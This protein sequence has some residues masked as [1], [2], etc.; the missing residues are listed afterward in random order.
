MNEE[1]LL[2][3]FESFGGQQK[4]GVDFKTWVSKI[5]D[6]EDYKKGMFENFGGQETLKA[7]YEDWNQK[8]FGL[9]KK[10]DTQSGLENTELDSSNNKT[11]SSS[12]FKDGI[13]VWDGDLNFPKK[14]DPLQDKIDKSL[15][16]IKEIA[17]TD[18][19]KKK[20]EERNTQLENQYKTAT[21]ITDIEKD[22]INKSILARS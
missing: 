18:E 16:G 9:K 8:V 2:G 4:L 17:S 10:D 13:K 11:S 22:S 15:L 12:D 1:Y 20:I 14:K 21:T 19:Y 6:N 7:S 3:A 5:Q